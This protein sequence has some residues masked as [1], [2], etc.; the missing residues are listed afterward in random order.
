M[1]PVKKKRLDGSTVSVTTKPKSP[2]SHVTSEWLCN[3]SS[4][5]L[6]WHQGLFDTRVVGGLQDRLKIKPCMLVFYFVFWVFFSTWHANC[7]L[8]WFLFFI[9]NYIYMYSSN[10]PLQKLWNLPVFQSTAALITEWRNTGSILLRFYLFCAS[11]SLTFV[12]GN[13]MI[14]FA[15]QLVLN[16]SVPPSVYTFSS[17]GKI[18]RCLCSSNM[19]AT[20]AHWCKFAVLCPFKDLQSC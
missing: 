3:E 1:P 8:S 19:V 16:R 2:A 14:Q 13:N 5:N 20:N 15:E 9:Y 12:K 17:L 18:S 6:T 11:Y 4:R 10:T 7:H